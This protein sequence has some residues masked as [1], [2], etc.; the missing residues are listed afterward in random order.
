MLL[1]PFDLLTARHPQDVA[2]PV[3]T[4]CLE[5]SK[6]DRVER[7][8]QTAR[9]RQLRVIAVSIRGRTVVLRGQVCSFHMKQ[10]AQVIALKIAGLGFLSNELTVAM[11]C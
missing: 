11:E 4:E 9:Y 10:M 5:M 3:D 7:A 6:V 1:A 8:L 2:L